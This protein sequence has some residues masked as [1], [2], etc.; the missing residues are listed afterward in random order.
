M[1][2]AA[3]ATAVAMLPHRIVGGRICHENG[4]FDRSFR[5]EVERPRLGSNR[6]A[7]R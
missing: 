6:M 2:G 7:L 5:V 3:L 1:T 4:L